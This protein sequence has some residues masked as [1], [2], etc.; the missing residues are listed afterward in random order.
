MLQWEPARVFPWRTF[1]SLGR[2]N[3]TKQIWNNTLPGLSW[4]DQMRSFTVSLIVPR[5]DTYIHSSLVYPLSPSIKDLIIAAGI[6]GLPT[7][8]TGFTCCF[9]SSTQTEPTVRINEISDSDMRCEEVLLTQ[10]FF[11]HVTSRETQNWI[12]LLVRKWPRC[13]M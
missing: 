4:R 3:L 10:H 1:H 7:S 6:Q 13:R 5:D 11:R 2:F 12:W 9:Q 8:I